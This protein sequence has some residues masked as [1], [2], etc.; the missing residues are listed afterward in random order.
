[1]GLH[2][3]PWDCLPRRL[4]RVGT[5]NDMQGLFGTQWDSMGLH[6]TLWDSMG[7]HGTATPRVMF[8]LISHFGT[9]KALLI[10]S[11]TY[12]YLP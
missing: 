12:I 6:M 4:K 9:R 11:D 10:P 1:M 3:T 2:G 7:L 8:S 5:C